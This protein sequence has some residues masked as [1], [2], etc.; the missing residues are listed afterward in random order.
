MLGNTSE[1][2]LKMSRWLPLKVLADL[3]IATTTVV[4]H[5]DTPNIFFSCDNHYSDPVL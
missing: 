4:D 1:S 3:V 2:L 5:K